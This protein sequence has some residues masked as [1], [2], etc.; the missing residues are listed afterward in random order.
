M[1]F[2]NSTFIGGK[3]TS[4]QTPTAIRNIKYVSLANGKYSDL[5]GTKYLPKDPIY[6]TLDPLGDINEDIN[7]EWDWDTIM[8]TRFAEESLIAGNVNWTL[9]TVDNLVIRRRVEGSHDWLTI[10]VYPIEVE[11]DFNFT[12]IDKYNQSSTN[13]EYSIVPYLNGNPG[14]YTIKEIFSDFDAI[15]INDDDFS[16]KTF[17]TDGA[18]DT[19]R[20]ISGNY[21]VPILSKYPVFFHVGEMNYDSGSVNGTFFELDDGCIIKQDKAYAYKRGLMDFL[22]NGKPKILKHPDGRIWLMQVIP[23]PTDSAN[24]HYSIRN[25]SFEWIEVG[26]YDNN[27]DLY[28]SKLLNIPEKWWI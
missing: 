18:I 19:T 22:T 25:I 8:R 6:R 7:E 13:Y 17:C 11:E 10:G 21:N 28:W 9:N 26:K 15:F 16:Y 12:G 23:S 2:F 1:I 4:M 14:T 20:N 3:S 27:E 5:Y 24:G